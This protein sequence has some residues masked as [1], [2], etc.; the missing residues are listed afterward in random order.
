MLQVKAR[1]LMTSNRIAADAMF[2][3][4]LARRYVTVQD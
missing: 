2:D 4:N 3:A 1:T